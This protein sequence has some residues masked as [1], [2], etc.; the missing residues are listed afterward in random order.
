MN[1]AL[2]APIGVMA[3][4][5]NVPFLV[6]GIGVRLGVVVQEAGEPERG[7]AGHELLELLVEMSEDRPCMFGR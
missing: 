3:E 5:M 2:S 1:S 7:P 6:P 4:E